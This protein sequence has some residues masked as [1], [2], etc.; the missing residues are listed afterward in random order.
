MLVVQLKIAPEGSLVATTICE[1]PTRTPLTVMP[2]TAQSA[3]NEESPY[4]VIITTS[5][6]KV[7]G[8]SSPSIST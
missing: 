8:I 3:S 6:L 2:P 4:V 5:Q 7:K 1:V